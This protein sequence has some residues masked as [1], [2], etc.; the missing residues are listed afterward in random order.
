MQEETEALVQAIESLR[1]ESNPF[2]D[3]IF[4][5][6][7]GFFSALLGALVAYYTLRYQG[8]IQYEK[9]KIK[10]VNDWMFLAEDA[11]SSLVSTKQNYHGKLTSNPFQRTLQVRSLIHSTK[12]LDKEISSLSFIIPKKEDKKSHDIKW[13][14]LPRI[15]LIV[16]NYNFIIEL[17][18][19]RSEVERPLK[20]KILSDYT[21]K[22]YTEVTRDQIFK[23]VSQSDFT[24]L[25]DLTEAAIRHTDALIIE[26]NDFLSEFPNVCKGLI[27]E[28]YIKRYGPIITYNTEGKPKLISLIGKSPEV[29]FTILAELFGTTVESVK[30]EYDTG[31]D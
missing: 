13:R 7:T 29:D 23:S 3:Y 11:I 31:Y 8:H 27:K 22:V 4:P 9:E 17:W 6:V 2:K 26:I 28:K 19:K 1:Q 30:E 14:Q 25:I 24:V 5:L 16:K 10:A 18:N 15:R 21:D 20:E 12:D